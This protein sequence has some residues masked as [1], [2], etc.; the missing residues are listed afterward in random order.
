MWSDGKG[1][2][3]SKRGLGEGWGGDH[4]PI[5]LAIFPENL[6]KLKQN[7]PEGG[8]VLSTFPNRPMS[9]M[10]SLMVWLYAPNGSESIA[11]LTQRQ[12]RIVLDPGDDDR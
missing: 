10:I 11:I 7:G 12:W 4:Q 1:S 9:P 3:F 2:G 6:L 5:I 8:G